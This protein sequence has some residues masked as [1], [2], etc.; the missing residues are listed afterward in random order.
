M[1]SVFRVIPTQDHRH[2]RHAR[3]VPDFQEVHVPSNDEIAAQLAAIGDK[4]GEL[5]EAVAALAPKVAAELADRLRA[6]LPGE[7]P[8]PT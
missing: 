3:Y 7:A 4:L 6:P 5:S 1:D 8:D 2:A